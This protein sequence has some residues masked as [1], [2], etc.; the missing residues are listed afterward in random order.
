MWVPVESKVKVEVPQAGASLAGTHLASFG[1]PQPNSAAEVHKYAHKCT[2]PWVLSALHL[3]A[4]CPEEITPL[5]SVG[6]ILYDAPGTLEKAQRARQLP[7]EAGGISVARGSP[8][9]L[10]P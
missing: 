9:W 6:S 10:G 8:T 5:S 2:N 1:S 3:S 4:G 7:S